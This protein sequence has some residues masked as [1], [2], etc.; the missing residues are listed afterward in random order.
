MAT[1]FKACCVEGCKRDAGVRG[2]ARGFC[3][4]HYKRWS[5]HGDPLSGGTGMGDRLEWIEAHQGYTGD[6]CLK[7]PFS[8]TE[9]GYGQ[10]KIKGRSTLASRVMCEA[11]HGPAPTPE[12]QA[13]HSC[14]N[15]H[16]G[17]MTP[18]HLRWATRLENTDDARRHGTLVFG[19]K[20][21]S[22]KLTA[23]DVRRIRRLANEMSQPAIARI[24]GVS[25]QQV[26][27]IIRREQWAW[28]V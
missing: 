24:I 6:E 12:H 10:F 20:Q 21:G 19:D 15:G 27:K 7:W 13:A 18:K 11:V 25:R 3:K 5:R 23:A 4:S 28:M 8:L 17:C 16:E 9:A 26:G 2:T 1:M 22:S 14:G